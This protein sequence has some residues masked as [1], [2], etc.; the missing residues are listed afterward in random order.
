MK[1]GKILITLIASF[2]LSISAAGTASATQPQPSPESA[3][4]TCQAV[5]KKNVRLIEEKN[6][7]VVEQAKQHA[8]HAIKANSVS[9]HSP[10]ESIRI[11]DSTV[12]Q[13]E[14]DDGQR[15]IS[16]TMPL[17]GS[18]LRL[19]SNLTV[20]LTPNNTVAT[21][22]ET[23]VTENEAGNFQ[24]TTYTDG[25]LA[26]D[27]DTGQKAIGD[28]AL[29]AQIDEINS[30]IQN[31]QQTNAGDKAQPAGIGTVAAC[32]ATVLGIGGATAW[33]IAS[34]CGGSCA[35]VAT[36]VGAAI[37]AAC[38]GAV[39]TIGTGAISGAVSCFGYM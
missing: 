30:A 14:K 16:I 39:A 7:A 18:N 10:N 26:Q 8:L 25:K 34:L 28:E 12:L 9:L 17:R 27:I 31:H 22:S 4:N 15:Y 38:I 5:A 19:M 1:L 21:Y 32:L 23:L 11:S 35:A 33:I 24:L 2:A 3:A 36:G 37:C 20:V 29:K 6:P 13:L